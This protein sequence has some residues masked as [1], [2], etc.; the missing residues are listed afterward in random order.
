MKDLEKL[1][2]TGER[3]SR[4]ELG[5]LWAGERSDPDA[6]ALRT[7]AQEQ[8][9]AQAYLEALDQERGRVPPFD[10]NILRSRAH[11]IEQDEQRATQREARQSRRLGARWWSALLPGLGF[12]A[13]AALAVVV[14]LPDA[15]TRSRHVTPQ[16]LVGTKGAA[17]VEFFLLRDGEVHPGNEDELHW[18]GDR[19]QFRYR[20]L[21]EST[22]VL[23][24]LDGRGDLNLYY[25]AAGD[26]P[27]P[28]VPGE[29]RTLE[30]SIELDDAPDFEL[31]LAYFGHD[32][33]GV[34]MDEVE[35]I[36]DEEG[37]EGLLLLAEEVEDV[38][39]IL[40]RKGEEGPAAG[41]RP[42]A[43]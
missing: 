41:D 25:P 4:L 40:L 24:S 20:T 14:L 30:G 23:L 31:V 43:P 35:A 9:G 21:G 6:E 11:A 12:A 22:L 2:N 18:A 16:Q 38:D 29:L 19:I 32:S 26:A 27:V 3:P 8:P 33:V 36:Y 5:Q 37:R 34:V 10:A 17:T 1:I 15:S 7:K 42:G 28:V 39:A 13:A